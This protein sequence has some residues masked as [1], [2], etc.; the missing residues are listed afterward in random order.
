MI[1]TK[2]YFPYNPAEPVEIIGEVHTIEDG[3]ILLDHIPFENSIRI[4]DFVQ[5]DSV[6]ILPHQFRCEYGSDLYY[7][8][9]NCLVYFNEQMNGTR[10]VVS[11]LCVG[12]I[13]IASDLNEIKRH[14]ENVLIHTPYE[15][16]TASTL[17]KGGIRPG[18]GLEMVGDILNVTL[19]G[20]EVPLA[21]LQATI[22]DLSYRITCLEQAVE[23]LQPKQPDIWRQVKSDDKATCVINHTDQTYEDEMDRML[24][25]NA[26]GTPWDEMPFTR[27]FL[28][29]RY[30]INNYSEKQDGYLRLPA[31]YANLT[32]GSDYIF[33]IP[34][35]ASHIQQVELSVYKFVY[36]ETFTD[37]EG[38]DDL[39]PIPADQ[40]APFDVQLTPYF[41]VWLSQDALDLVEW[42]NSDEDWGNLWFFIY[43][44]ESV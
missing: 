3:V 41:W 25:L 5:T 17:Q 16:P 10:V 29:S 42:Y 18:K 2:T 30:C 27:N 23:L 6:S 14:L 39:I 40:V 21:D 22:V 1:L 4:P 13:I 26:E 31:E 15:L 37:G 24:A 35:N 9:S 8:E 44:K 11:Y 33:L 34:P 19:Q 38:F 28:C 32:Y 36:P 7:R 20:G 12:T 43:R